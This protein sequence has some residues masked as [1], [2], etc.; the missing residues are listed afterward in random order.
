MNKKNF[1]MQFLDRNKFD[2]PV[3]K[4]NNDAM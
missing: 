3:S 2:D 1:R 4:I